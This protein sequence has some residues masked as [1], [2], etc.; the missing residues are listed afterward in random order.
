MAKLL[1]K[2]HAPEQ[3]GRVLQI[4]PESAG[5]KYVGFE[6][7]QL[8][9]RQTLAFAA[10][11]D[12]ERCLVLLTGKIHLRAGKEDFGIIGEREHLF[13]GR[14]PYALYVPPGESFSIH[15][16]GPAEIALCAAPRA[17]QSP[18]L[19]L[20]HPSDVGVETRGS[21]TN[22]RVVHNILP[23]NVPAGRLLVVEVYTPA[24]HWSS[25]PPHKHDRAAPPHETQLEETYYHRIDP[26]QG[27]AFQRVYTD[28]RDID[29]TMAVEDGDVVLVPRGY[30]PVGAAH[31]YNL[32]YL[33][34]MAGPERRWIFKNDPAHEWMLAKAR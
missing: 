9:A 8:I 32:Y 23:D 18:A 34:V 14:R 26:P 24:G 10:E 6:V 2:T 17:E 20:I 4:T 33:N 25:Y 27:F 16:E 1:V 3:S 22:T 15:A 31:G 28:S 30:H 13:D 7:F 12:K 29:E 5:W 11:A 21:G 19:R